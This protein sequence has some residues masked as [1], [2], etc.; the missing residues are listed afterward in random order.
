MSAS[1]VFLKTDIVFTLFEAWTGAWSK[2]RQLGVITQLIFP[3][4]WVSSGNAA[5]FQSLRD[6]NNNTAVG[7]LYVP[8]PFA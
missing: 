3:S 2:F 6:P 1:N 5:A 8:K 7:E 4:A